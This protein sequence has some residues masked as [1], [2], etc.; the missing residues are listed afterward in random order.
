MIEVRY[1]TKADIEGYNGGP[2][3]HTMRGV[4]VE[5]DGEIKGIAG[6]YRTDGGQMVFIDMDD[7]LVNHPRVIVKAARMVLSLCERYTRVLAFADPEKE[8]AER[9]A[10]HFGFTPTGGV[11]EHGKVYVRWNK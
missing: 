2:P 11:S 6:V 7:E 4:C 3:F 1:A 5:I 8:T 9:F 10:E